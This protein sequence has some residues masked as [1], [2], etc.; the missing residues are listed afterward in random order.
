M[1]ALEKELENNKSRM[2]E[3]QALG[4]L[5]LVEQEELNSLREANEELE[6]QLLIKKEL[7]RVAGK[8]AEEAA[9]AVIGDKTTRATAWAARA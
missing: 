4:A 1:E 5:K 2:E 3:L 8:D 6:T 7:A 9:K